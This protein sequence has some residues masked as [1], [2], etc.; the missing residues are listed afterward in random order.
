VAVGVPVTYIWG[1][2]VGVVISFLT[3]PFALMIVAIATDRA[4]LL[5]LAPTT[6]SSSK[7]A[8]LIEGLL[9]LDQSGQGF[10]DLQPPGS[11]EERAKPA[12]CSTGGVAHTVALVDE[13]GGVLFRKTDASALIVEH[14]GERLPL[15]GVMLVDTASGGELSTA[16]EA[17]SMF[18]LPSDL[19]LP[20]KIAIQHHLIAAGD[21]VC[22]SGIIEELALDPYRSVDYRRRV[23]A[24][25]GQPI[26]VERRPRPR[27]KLDRAQWPLID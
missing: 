26:R 11:T 5:V 27:A 10:V 9:H 6:R 17:R 23:V 2:F 13:R 22:V 19:V 1:V 16:D 4:P 7:Q 12:I 15:Q 18:N 21:P 14:E 8:S 24:T 20:S 25:P 3:F